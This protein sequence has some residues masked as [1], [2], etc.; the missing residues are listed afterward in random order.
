MYM[1]YLFKALHELEKHPSHSIHASGFR[2][3]VDDLRTFIDNFTSELSEPWTHSTGVLFDL[4]H[5]DLKGLKMGDSRF[6]KPRLFLYAEINQKQNFTLEWSPYFKNATSIKDLDFKDLSLSICNS[7]NNR[8]LWFQDITVLRLY[9]ETD[10]QK[11]AENLIHS[12]QAKIYEITTFLKQNFDIV[13]CSEFKI[14][15]ENNK[16]INFDVVRHEREIYHSFSS[17]RYASSVS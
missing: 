2:I 3:N 15:E 5:R 10:L 9:L 14:Q 4:N 12:V 16:I 7:P 11:V 6:R 8:L 1:H 17:P 13:I